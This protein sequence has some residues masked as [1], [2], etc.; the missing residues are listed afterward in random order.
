VLFRIDVIEKSEAFKNEE[1]QQHF[2]D[3]VKREIIVF[4]LNQ[5]LNELDDLARKFEGIYK[6]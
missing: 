6:N 3:N 1:Y 4:C 5:R 2:L